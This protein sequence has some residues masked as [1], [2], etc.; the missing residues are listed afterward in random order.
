[1]RGR[2]SHRLLSNYKNMNQYHKIYSPTKIVFES[3]AFGYF[4]AGIGLI[5]MGEISLIQ[6]PSLFG[7]LTI[8]TGA[9]IIK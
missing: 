8:L 1:M 5:I 3:I 7:M 6:N 4:M 9:V 2:H